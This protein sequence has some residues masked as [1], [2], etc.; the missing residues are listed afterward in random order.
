MALDRGEAFESFK[1]SLLTRARTVRF[2]IH[3]HLSSPTYSYRDWF[4]VDPRATEKTEA[5][6]VPTTWESYLEATL[7]ESRWIDG[8]SL[9]AAAKRYGIFIV[10]VPLGVNKGD[11]VCFGEPKAAKDP[12]VLLWRNCHYTLARLRPGKRWPREWLAAEQASVVAALFRGRG[13]DETVPFTPLKDRKT[14]RAAETPETWR[15]AHTP[16]STAPGSSKRTVS[17]EKW[18]PSCTPASSSSSKRARITGPSADTAGPTAAKHSLKS[19]APLPSPLG[20]AKGYTTGITQ[21]QTKVATK[22]QKDKQQEFP[23][24][25]VRAADGFFHWKCH[26][27][28]EKR[29]SDSKDKLRALK[30]THRSSKHPD[31]PWTEFLVRPF[32][33]VV[34]AS[35]DTPAVEGGWECPYCKARLPKQKVRARHLSVDHH[36][37]TAHP[38]VSPKRWQAKMTSKRYKG[39]KKADTYSVKLAARN[40]RN[41]E[42]KFA[43]H[44]VVQVP[45][46]ATHAA[47]ASF[48]HRYEYWRVNCLTKLG[49]YGGGSKVRQLKLT[50][51][52][53]RKLPHAKARIRAAWKRLEGRSS[54]SGDLVHN[55]VSAWVRNLLEDGD[56]ERQPGPHSCSLACAC[57]NVGGVKGCWTAL[58]EVV[59]RFEAVL[60]QE[61]CF[62]DEEEEA[63]F[64][65]FAFKKGYRCWNIRGHT[66]AG[67]GYRGVAILVKFGFRASLLSTW[68]HREEQILAVH[69]EGI[70][71]LSLYSSVHGGNAEIEDQVME[72]LE[73]HEGC[74][75]WVLCGDHNALP[76]QNPLVDLL[77]RGSG[78]LMIVKDEQGNALPTRLGGARCIDYGVYRG[79]TLSGPCR[80]DDSVVADHRVITFSVA[81]PHKLNNRGLCTLAKTAN[82]AKPAHIS[83]EVW[84]N[85]V[86]KHWTLRGG[87]HVP[88]DADQ[89]E[90]DKNWEAFC[91]LLEDTL[92]DAGS[93]AAASFPDPEGGHLQTLRR[94]RCRKN[95]LSI[96]RTQ[97]FQG[98]TKA[99]QSTFHE[100]SLHKV[101]FRLSEMIR[102]ERL[103]R[104]DSHAYQ[105][106]GAKIALWPEL[107]Q[108]STEER[109][110]CARALLDSLRN[111]Q[112]KARM[113]TWKTRL[114]GNPVECYRWLKGAPTVPTF[115][116]YSAAVPGVQSSE[117]ASALDLLTRHWRKLWDR[118]C[119]WR[120]ALRRLKEHRS[121]AI[122]AQDWQPMTLEEIKKALAKQ[123]GK[124]AGGDHWSG[125]EVADLPDCVLENLHLLPG[126]WQDNAMSLSKAP[127]KAL[128]VLTPLSF[129]LSPSFPYGRGFLVAPCCS[130]KVRNAGCNNGGLKRLLEANGVPRSTMQSAS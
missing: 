10:V 101:I 119:D 20:A 69:I 2:D 3:K 112:D 41:R 126:K 64:R 91:A 110:R 73:S 111:S 50:C 35:L 14:W 36:H 62:R 32:I 23:D 113:A 84:Q 90:L 107:R 83:T 74:F 38:R 19:S 88:H 5:G 78:G 115:R 57:V 29:R 49:G 100:G 42:K 99:P 97:V 18:R 26:I 16:A 70:T 105:T 92:V 95:K 33:D 53:S 103:G 127:K 37:K 22:S 116:L 109:L 54:E 15:P 125:S 94:H 71:F 39:V 28:Q 21:G 82:L 25:T 46:T 108:G 75:P 6:S 68:H 43:S 123:R 66:T 52:Q 77:T 17:I 58:R 30:R 4:E 11:P 12:V 59:H 56:V 65:R 47:A 67:K 48:R 114:R 8:L 80:F 61:T 45:V 93:E 106:L 120:Q 89:A 13:K 118:R 102:L 122:P 63:A 124:S 72:W 27:C 117:P 7:R 87:F 24:E 104:A 31:V 86:T 34:E 55:Q 9:K 85:L 130:R 60:L 96:L 51:A 98:S 44:E 79:T 128:R 40:K 81:L 129:A 1:D 121:Q 76:H